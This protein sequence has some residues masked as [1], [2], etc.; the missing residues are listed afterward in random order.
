[1]SKGQKINFL[2]LTGNLAKDPVITEKATFLTIATWNGK[3][4]DGKE[5]PATFIDVSFFG[6]AK[7]TAKELKKGAR[8]NLKGKLSNLKDQATGYTKLTVLGLSCNKLTK[9]VTKE[10]SKEEVFD[11]WIKTLKL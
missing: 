8:I 9:S 3:A 11:E 7:E 2:E 5:R 6:K 10:I 1:M 4:K